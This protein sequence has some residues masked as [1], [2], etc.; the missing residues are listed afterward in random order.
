[1]NFPSEHVVQFRQIMATWTNFWTQNQSEQY[2]MVN[3]YTYLRF[4][5][6]IMWTAGPN[7]NL[8]LTEATGMDMNGCV[9]PNDNHFA[10][11]RAIGGL[12]GPH[13]DKT[14]N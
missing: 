4:C 10:L 7:D 9:M 6:N 11:F 8:W 3:L 13:G 1:M 5:G 2:G 12:V 14:K